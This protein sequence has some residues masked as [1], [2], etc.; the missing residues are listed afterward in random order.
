MPKRKEI[1]TEKI[2]PYHISGKAM[3]GKEIFGKEEDRA[4]FV[5]Q[6]YAANVG[7][8]VINL[9]RKNIFE[10]SN[11][12]LQGGEIPKGF[13]VA[14]H[15]P[16][17]HLF[18]FALGKERYHLGLVPAKKEGI[19]LYMQK[20]NLGFAKYYNLKNKRTGTL[21]EGRFKAAPIINPK[22]LESIV[23]Y[24]NIKRVMDILGTEA[25]SGYPYSSFPDLF[26]NRVSHLLSKEGRGNLVKIL[27]EDFFA[28]RE[29]YRDY[30][31]EFSNKG[32]TLRRNLFLD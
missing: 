12:L 24:I 31:E 16:L 30:I 3:E 23:K 13:V 27:G 17:V 10:I 20:L 14:E 29:D 5:F 8:P 2:R 1:L 32:E 25:L 7:R 9:Y 26:G 15:D 6:M 18:S 22:Q 28:T 21:F 11:A 4:R 19:P